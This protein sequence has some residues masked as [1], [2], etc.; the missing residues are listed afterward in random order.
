MEKLKAVTSAVTDQM[1]GIPTVSMNMPKA[2]TDQM[3]KLQGS[4]VVTGEAHF[5]EVSED[6]LFLLL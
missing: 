4:N 2:L 1:G 5:L 6:L 3:G